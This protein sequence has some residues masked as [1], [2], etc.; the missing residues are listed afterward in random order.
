MNARVPITND[1]RMMRI[2]RAITKLRW[3]KNYRCRGRLAR[4][5]GFLLGHWALLWSLI[6][7]H[8][9]FS[10]L[11]INDLQGTAER[12]SAHGDFGLPQSL[13]H[14]WVGPANAFSHLNRCETKK[15]N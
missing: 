1:Q 12:I 10:R 15:K 2:R 4:F 7:E 9:S 14:L 6:T 3:S 13:S 5:H 8:W 11:R